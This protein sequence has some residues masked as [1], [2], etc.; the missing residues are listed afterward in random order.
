[1]YSGENE[2]H[3]VDLDGKEKMIEYD[4]YYDDDWDYDREITENS[5]YNDVTNNESSIQSQ[6][7]QGKKR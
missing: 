1:V 6:G 4:D 2:I 7:N 5:T 3:H